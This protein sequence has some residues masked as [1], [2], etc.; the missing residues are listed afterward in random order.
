MEKYRMFP[1]FIDLAVA[2]NQLEIEREAS[3]KERLAAFGA[4]GS[5]DGIGSKLGRLVGAAKSIFGQSSKLK[6][7]SSSGSMA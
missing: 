7:Q 2:M 4:G 5:A 3:K 1:T 6:G